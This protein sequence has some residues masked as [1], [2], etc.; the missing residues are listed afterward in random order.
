MSWKQVDDSG[1]SLKWGLAHVCC[2]RYARHDW[3]APRRIPLTEKRQVTPERE[4]TILKGEKEVFKGGLND[5]MG[6]LRGVVVMIMN[7]RSS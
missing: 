5:L 2:S 1:V 4:A 7:H 6:F 3:S